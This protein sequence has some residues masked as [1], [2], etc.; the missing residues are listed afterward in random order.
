VERSD[1]AG[2]V[3]PTTTWFS[4][5]EFFKKLP[6]N[7]GA[8]QEKDYYFNSYSSFY[9]HEEM[10]KDRVIF[11]ILIYFTVDKNRFVPKCNSEQSRGV[12]G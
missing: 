2:F 8:K 12:Q 10:I 3:G 1:E 9:I 4:D 6:S 11:Y 5:E 7:M